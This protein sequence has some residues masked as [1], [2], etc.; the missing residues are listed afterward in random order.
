MKTILR[1][2]ADILFPP[3][4]V[5]CETILEADLH[6]SFC[7]ACFSEIRFINPPLCP[8]CGL[9]YFTE[10]ASDHPCGDCLSKKQYFTS[11][12]S[13]GV[14]ETSLLKTIQ[15]FKYQG[16]LHAGE[17]LGSLM[18]VWCHQAFDVG[19]YDVIMPVPLH[20][21]RLRERGFNQ[22]LVL[23][24]AMARRF[25]VE[26]DFMTLRRTAST[27]PQ[28]GLKKEERARN[29]R[30]AFKLENGHRV[31]GKKVLLIDDVYTT[32]STVRECAR[33]LTTG[34]AGR[35]GV[36]TLARAL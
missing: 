32:G 7:P 16:S 18:A 21:Q 1:G 24:R 26:L 28:T 3:A 4:C 29:V 12:R 5:V 35:V 15:R 6:H 9:P 23:A 20:L 34:G 10:A 33:I 27:A 11:V 2:L 36:L 30:G 25:S 17:A 8:R 13:L 31:K 14:Y 22:S 19:E